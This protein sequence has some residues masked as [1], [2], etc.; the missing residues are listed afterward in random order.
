[1]KK[2][3]FA[4]LL[5]VMLVFLLVAC[6]S[7]D[8]LSGKWYRVSKY[9]GS[10]ELILEIYNNSGTIDID[11]VTYS[12]TNIDTEKS[13]MTVNAGS[14]YTVP[15]SYDEDGKLTITEDSLYGSSYRVIYYKENSKALKEAVNDAKNDD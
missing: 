6:S 13:Q 5:M 7:K 4:V 8:D 10:T 2:K 9:D 3:L 11:G 1:M 15:Y 12:I 14:D